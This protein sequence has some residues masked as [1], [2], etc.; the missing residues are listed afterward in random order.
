MPW[1]VSSMTMRSRRAAMAMIASMSQAA[2]HMWTGTTARVRGP[3][4]SSTAFGSMVMLSSTST[5]TGMA[6]TASTAVAVAM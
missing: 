1:Q 4:A 3:I 5:I 2:P 6:P